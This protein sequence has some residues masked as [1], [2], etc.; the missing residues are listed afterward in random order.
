VRVGRGSQAAPP[1]KN[2]Q[3]KIKNHLQ[4]PPIGRTDATIRLC[5]A[6]DV[7]LV[8]AVPLVPTALVDALPPAAGRLAL[9][10]LVSL[11]EPAVPARL[12]AVLRSR[13]RLVALALAEVSD[14][15]P[16][17]DAALFVLL[18]FDGAL[19][20]GEV[21][22][23]ELFDEPGALLAMVPTTSTRWPT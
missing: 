8:A 6:P 23:P 21:L 20:L 17:A 5:I 2:Q 15:S 7:P 10:L 19:A 9:A 4:L 3:S 13:S 16:A 22:A 11:E 14:R 18:P 1:I 12:V